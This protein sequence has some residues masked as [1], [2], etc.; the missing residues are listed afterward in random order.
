MRKIYF[1]KKK[2]RSNCYYV[3]NT[4]RRYFSSNHVKPVYQYSFILNDY[5]AEL[6]ESDEF[7]MT[8]TIYTPFLQ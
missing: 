1:V 5:N 4:L 7:N 3:I 8:K 6:R 2:R